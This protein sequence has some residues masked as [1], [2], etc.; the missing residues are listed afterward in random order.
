MFSIHFLHRMVACLRTLL[1][2]DAGLLE[3]IPALPLS[4]VAFLSTEVRRCSGDEQK[5]PG[6]RT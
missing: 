3:E 6:H 4:L 5:E 1:T 2:W